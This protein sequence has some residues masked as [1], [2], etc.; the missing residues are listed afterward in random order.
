MLSQ[1]NTESDASMTL[2]TIAIIMDSTVM[3]INGET[4]SSIWPGTQWV[5]FIV[6]YVNNMK[7]FK[8][9][10]YNTQY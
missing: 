8:R 6:V 1:H 10:S 9:S 4:V 2:S 5:P 3:Y 7:E